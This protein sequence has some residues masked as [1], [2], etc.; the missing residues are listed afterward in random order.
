MATKKD[1]IRLKAEAY[2]IENMEAS[3]KEVAALYKVTELTVSRWVQKYNWEEKRMNF[4]ASPTVIKQ[5]LQQETLH[6]INGGVPTFSATGVEKLMKA[7]D[8]CDKQADPVVV[9][10]ILKDLDNFISEVDPAFAAQCTQYHK[11]FLQH[12][13][14]IEING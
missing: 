10:R 12:R 2:Y 8:R 3:Q 5:K 14:S 4:H 9:H 13:I 7:L 1:S 11:Q 6:I